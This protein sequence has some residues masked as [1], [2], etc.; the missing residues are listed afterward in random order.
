MRFKPVLI[1]LA[2]V[3]I[4]FVVTLKAFDWL[5]PRAL[6]P[7]TLQALPPL[8]A[9][10]PSSVVVP[11]SIPLT[12]I[13]DLVDRTA[14]RNFAGKAD[15]PMPQLV[16][17]ADINWT[18]ARGAVA[19]RGASEQVTV[20]A[21]LTGTLSA[22][23]SLSTSAQGQVGDALGK[24][25]G[26]KVAKQVGVNIKSFSAN[27]E[28]KGTIAITA[29]PKVLPDWHVDPNLSA[30]VIL[31]DSNVAIGGAR[32]NVPAQVKPVIDKAVNDQVS[33]LQQTIRNDGALERSARRE[34]ARIC[35]SIPL[36]GAGVPNGFWLELRPTKA[37]AAQPQ[38][39]AATVALTLGIVAESRITTAPTKPECP[40]P[41]ALEMVAPN[42]TGVKVAVPIDIPFQ[43]LDRVIEPQFVGRTFPENGSG[44]AAIT[45]KRVK[46][47]A[48]GDR[49]L[50]SML[51]DAK[52][53]SWFGFGGEATLHIWGRPVL[54]QED[55]TLRLSDMQLA[56]E[57][58]AAF[59][60]L[61]EA[62]R[63]AVPYLQ[64]AISDR[65]VF[66]LKADSANVQRRIG[67]VIATYQ[68]NE[69]GLRISSEISSLRLTDLAF[70]S[71]MLRVTAEA[72]GILEVTVTKLKAP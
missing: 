62:A 17:N 9:I 21:P 14:P 51:V 22:K 38:I 46:V 70:D 50:V 68:R 4:S 3:V 58:E 23:G 53:K 61:G 65:A 63:A 11:V 20:T 33:Q 59:G 43:E 41:A 44:N 64:K 35:R 27:G 28:I 55:Q 40:F 54:N 30:Q 24:L 10:R 32:I 12:A 6:S 48:S 52:E 72:N 66:D 7:P 1:A 34:W 15:N 56:V 29:K 60:L 39:D 25:F 69:D 49:L 67:A 57:S 45:V 2:I 8:P 13:R 16:Q 47:A 5:S 71:N 19:V 36:Q 37:L 42:S 31:S 18:V 26:D